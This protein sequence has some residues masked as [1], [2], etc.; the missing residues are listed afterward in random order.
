MTKKKKPK[1]GQGDA[2]LAAALHDRADEIN[3]AVV[4]PD[5]QEL[6]AIREEAKD[7]AKAGK[8]LKA[9]VAAYVDRAHDAVPKDRP[10]LLAELE[11][12]LRAL[13]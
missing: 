3:D 4:Q 10:E 9:D 13:L 6:G 1:P 5:W 12:E 11:R 7:R 2:D 8:L